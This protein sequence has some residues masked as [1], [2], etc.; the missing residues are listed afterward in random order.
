MLGL[1]VFGIATIV[2]LFIGRGAPMIGVIGGLCFTA[3]PFIAQEAFGLG[4]LEMAIMALAGIV[5]MFVF[6]ERVRMW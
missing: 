2:L 3:F 1:A 4:D 5:V 6:L